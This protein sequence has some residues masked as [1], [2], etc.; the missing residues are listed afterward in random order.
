MKSLKSLMCLLFIFVLIS[1]AFAAKNVKSD[2][3]E[4]DASKAWTFTLKG[5]FDIMGEAT[6]GSLPEG[7]VENSFSIG[8][9]AIKLFNPQMYLGAG[10]M[11]QLPRGIE[12]EGWEDVSFN[13]LPVYGLLKFIVPADNINLFFVLNIGYNFLFIDLPAP[14][15]DV[16]ANG[17]LYYGFGGGLL[18]SNNMQ[19]ELL[20]SVN[21]G[22][23]EYAGESEDVEYSKVMLS[24]GINF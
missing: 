5:G 9:E 22:S 7:D 23:L 8:G 19:I 11:Y 13:C 15:D 1:S 14:Y 21:N 12:E 18:F 4:S 3:D 6:L 24:V 2:N 10:A 20:Y 16:D 17:G